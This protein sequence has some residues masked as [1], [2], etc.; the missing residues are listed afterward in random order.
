MRM[1]FGKYKGRDIEKVP[2][3]YLKWCLKNNALRGKALTYAKRKLNQ[4]KDKYR[5]T[6]ED[7]VVG[8]GIYIVDAY[9]RKDAINMVM[10]ENNIRCTQSYHGTSFCAVKIN[11][12]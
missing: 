5:V 3:D 1:Q 6:V 2:D 7:A 9:S 12:Q 10:S 8:D 4:P 11:E